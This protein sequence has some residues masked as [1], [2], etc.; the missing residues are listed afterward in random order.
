MIELP[1]NIIKRPHY[2]NRVEP[3]MRKNIIKVFIGQRRVGKSYLLFQI[4]QHI[5]EQ[6]QQTKIIYINKEDLAFSTIKTALDLN[7]YVKT[8]KS[9]IEKTYLF[10][11][12]IQDIVDFHLALRSL[13]LDEQMDIYCTGCNANMLSSDIAGFLSGRYIEITVYSLSYIEFLNFHKLENTSKSLDIFL[14]FGGLPYLKHLALEDNIVFE[15]LRNI[16]STIVYK[17]IIQRFA[18]RNVLFLEQLVQFLANNIGSIFSIKRISDFLISQNTKMPPNQVQIYMQHLVNAFLIHRVPRFDI[19]GKRLFEVGDKYYFENLGI[20]HA[21]WGYR[22]EDKGKILENAVYNQLL[23]LG[24]QVKVGVL[25]VHEIDFVAEKE[26]E[27]W[28]LQ[29]ALFIHDEKTMEREFGN[30]SRI[31]DNYRKTVITYDAYSGNS[32]Q[33]IEL[34]DLKSFLAE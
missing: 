2:L 30:L 4:I 32:Y 26:G 16:Y 21:L 19:I 22:I 8:H 3:F 27:K 20:R 29:V 28:Y 7:E 14:K 25:G 23:F 13:L 5:L 10:I 11:D 33:G 34:T 31:S 9:A 17:D 24:Y 12:E 1:K 18:I 6:D 15:Y